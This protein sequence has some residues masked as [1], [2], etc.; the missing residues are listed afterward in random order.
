[1]KIRVEWLRPLHPGTKARAGYG[2]YAVIAGAASEP[3]VSM[4][5]STLPSKP[6]T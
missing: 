1:M 3:T 2:T 5:I 4:M 6:K